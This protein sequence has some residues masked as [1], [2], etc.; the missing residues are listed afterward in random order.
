VEQGTSATRR[1]GHVPGEAGAAPAFAP[2]HLQRQPKL[3]N[4]TP[5]TESKVINERKNSAFAVLAVFAVLCATVVAFGKA[6]GNLSYAMGA[7]TGQLFVIGVMVGLFSIFK[8]FR[9]RQTLTRVVLG[10]AIFLFLVS[11]VMPPV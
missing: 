4:P 6:R 10:V 11:V 3:M 9:N 8:R 5:E 1:I 2:A 7:A